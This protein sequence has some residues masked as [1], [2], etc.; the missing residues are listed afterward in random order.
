METEASPKERKSQQL[1]QLHHSPSMSVMDGDHR[2]IQ[3][4]PFTIWTAMGIGHSIT[5]TAI[6]VIVGLASGIALGGPPLF[7][8]GF[9]IM[10]IIAVCVAISLGELASA[11]PHS[12]GPQYQWFLRQRKG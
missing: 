7:I 6:T 11:L 9:I 5:N 8:Y 2:Q 1:D 12:G 10:A 4:K 3:Q